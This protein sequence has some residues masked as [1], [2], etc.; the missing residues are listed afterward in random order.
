MEGLQR[1]TR[2]YEVPTGSNFY[3]SL[4]K[5]FKG[6]SRKDCARLEGRKLKMTD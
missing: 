1:F 5:I 6:A 2:A 3:K 4:I